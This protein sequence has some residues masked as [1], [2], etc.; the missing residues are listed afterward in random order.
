M[1]APYDNR[2]NPIPPVPA[3]AEKRRDLRIPIR[4]LRVDTNLRGEVFFGYAKDISTSGLFIE[5]SNPRPVGTRVPLKFSLPQSDAKIACLGEVIWARDY[6]GARQ[7]APGMGIRFVE[8]AA[9]D[10]SL[11]SDFIESESDN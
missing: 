6:K 10:S 11:L 9:S 8:I 7:P 1:S 4:V 2:D 3:E 5:T